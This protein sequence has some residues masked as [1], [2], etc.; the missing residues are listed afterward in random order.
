MAS[1]IW[2]LSGFDES[3]L[4]NIHTPVTPLRAAQRTNRNEKNN[5]DL[6]ISQHFVILIIAIIKQSYTDTSLSLELYKYCFV[7]QYL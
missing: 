6:S 4:S 5:C 2:N 3:Y 7:K 1:V